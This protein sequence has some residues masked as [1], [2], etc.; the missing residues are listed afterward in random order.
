MKR[1]MEVKPLAELKP[2]EKGKIVKVKGI[3]AVR[4]R[5]LDMG[6]VPGAELE[7]ERMAPLGDPVEIRIKGYH[8]S[9]RNFEAE[10]I[11][12]EV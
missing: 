6:V 9:L 4:R 11:V 3:G 5:I 1:N 10:N 2:K 7:M 8:L 12:V